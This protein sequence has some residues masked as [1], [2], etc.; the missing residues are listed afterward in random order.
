MR[1][2]AAVGIVV[3]LVACGL[4]EPMPEPAAERPGGERPLPPPAFISGV[5]GKPVSWC[6]QGCVD[7][8]VNHPAV[9]PKALPPFELELLDGAVIERATAIGP[10][11][12]N[13]ITDRERTEVTVNGTTLGEVPEAAEMLSVFVRFA[14]GGD[15]SYMWALDRPSD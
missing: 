13:G 5:A 15:A 14:Q 7:G 4:V 10:P 12:A 6:W 3:L 9:L 2:V 1:H 11:R 8:F